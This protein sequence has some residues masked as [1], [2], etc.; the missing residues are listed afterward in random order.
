MDRSSSTCQ[1]EILWVQLCRTSSANYS[2][3]NFS[4]EVILSSWKSAFEGDATSLFHLKMI[5]E[6]S[7]LSKDNQHHRMWPFKS[8]TLTEVLKSV[9][10]VKTRSSLVKKFAEIKLNVQT[11]N[12]QISTEYNL[13][14]K[15]VTKNR[16]ITHFLL[17]W[18]LVQIYISKVLKNNTNHFSKTCFETFAS[19]SF[20]QSYI[21]NF[22]FEIRSLKLL[23]FNF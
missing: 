7:W 9:A 2:Q 6:H 1:I 5:K 10:S 19:N 23:Y 8:E 15:Y 20:R 4:C 11:T 3:I 22:E 14:N 13:Y 21:R 17:Q 18:Q 16:M 12:R